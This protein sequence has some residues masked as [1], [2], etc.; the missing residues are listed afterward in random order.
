M[1]AA[2]NEELTS[3]TD[4]RSFPDRN[5]QITSSTSRFRLSADTIE[6]RRER[7][8]GGEQEWR[9]ARVQTSAPKSPDVQSAPLRSFFSLW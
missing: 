8:N 7:M 3:A 5:E 1:T 4:G 9:L 2:R 6:S